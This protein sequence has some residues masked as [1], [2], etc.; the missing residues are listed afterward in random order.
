MSAFLTSIVERARLLNKRI[1]FPEGDDERTR[2]AAERLA[3]DRVV[4]PVLVSSNTQ[5]APGVSCIDPKSS[6]LMRRYASLLYQRR[7][8]KGMTEHEA[9]RHAADPLYFAALALADGAVD[10]FV[11]GASTST[12]VTVRA[13]FHAVGVAEGHKLVSSF[14]IQVHPDPRWGD[15]GVILFAD[16]AV[17]P[18][19]NS[20]ELAE[21]AIAA[22]ENAS[23]FLNDTPRVAMLSFSTKGSAKHAKANAVIE[24]V[25]IIRARAPWVNVDGELQVDAALVPHVGASKA[26]GSPLAG[27][28]NVLIFPDLN[29][30]NIG[31]KLAERLGGCQSLGPFLQG[32][33]KPGNDLSRGCSVDD[34]YYVAAVTALQSAPDA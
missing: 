4:Q 13:L 17:V 30:A 26:P 31:Y 19:P 8:A 22:A 29:A 3:R 18:E 9:E 14:M 21:I 6:E 20:T 25:K 16:P 7:R 10:G 27:K 15:N 1:V 33:A 2:E 11:G 5:C 24:A 23:R 12:G 28:A 32:L 34:I